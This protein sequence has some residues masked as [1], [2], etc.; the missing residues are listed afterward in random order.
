[1]SNEVRLGQLR[2]IEVFWGHLRPTKA[3][4]KVLNFWRENS[5]LWHFWVGSSKSFWVGKVWL[6]ALLVI[7][8]LCFFAL[9]SALLV[10]CNLFSWCIASYFQLLVN[11]RAGNIDFDFFL[12][13]DRLR[14]N[15]CSGERCFPF[16]W[17]G[18]F[19]RFCGNHLPTK[20]ENI[21][22]KNLLFSI[23]ILNYKKLGSV[24]IL[25]IL[26]VFVLLWPQWPLISR[27]LF[28]CF[29]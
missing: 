29:Q 20:M 5:N 11:F 14:V 12:K 17:E 24:C 28:N 22:P 21:F 23:E 2:S 10:H 8:T 15:S 13:G 4:G 6:V 9:Q 7:F 16:L 27:L 26:L 1:M 25:L 19:H 3:I 18:G